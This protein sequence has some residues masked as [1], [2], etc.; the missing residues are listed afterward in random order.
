MNKIRAAVVGYGNI[1]KYVVEA[2]A[3][4]AKHTRELPDAYLTAEGNNVTEAFLKY[5]RPIVGELPVTARFT[6][7]RN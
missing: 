4:V 2:L 7:L 1:G 5:A 3:N 6:Q